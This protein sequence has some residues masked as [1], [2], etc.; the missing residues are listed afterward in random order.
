MAFTPST[1]KSKSA[2]VSNAN[3]QKQTLRGFGDQALDEAQEPDVQTQLDHAMQF[4]HGV[5]QPIQQQAEPSLE[6]DEETL[7][8]QA[9]PGLEEEEEELPV[10]AKLTIGHPGDKYEQEADQMAAK[11]MAMPD[12][13]VQREAMPEEEKENLQMK[14][15]LQRQA[16]SEED[17]ETLQAKPQVQAKGGTPAAPE[18]FEGQ[19]ASHRGGGQPLSDQTRAFMEPRFGADFSD[20][21]VHETADLANVIQAQAFTHGQDVYF[22]SGKYN[23]GSSGGKELLAHELTHVVQQQAIR[24]S[25][26]QRQAKHQS[27][28]YVV[29]DCESWHVRKEPN[30][31]S[32]NKPIQTL[33]RGQRK[34]LTPDWGTHEHRAKWFKVL[35]L[36]KE[37]YI[38][39]KPWIKVVNAEDSKGP[40]EDRVCKRKNG[41]YGHPLQLLYE[42]PEQKSEQGIS[43]FGATPEELS[44]ISDTL[45]LLPSSNYSS[46][47]RIVVTEALNGGKKTGG[48]TITKSDAERLMRKKG[49]FRQLSEETGWKQLPRIELTRDSFRKAQKRANN[50]DKLDLKVGR[51][52]V[53]GKIWDTLLHE[54]GHAVEKVYDIKKHIRIDNF[55]NTCYGG[56]NKSSRCG[57]E[58][59]RFADAYM[60]Y[61]T[62]KHSLKSPEKETIEEVLKDVEEQYGSSR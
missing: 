10:Q 47:P 41:W 16:V 37:A 59:E 18:N 26:V 61:F 6:E 8:R 52:P 24:A 3:V 51:T 9:E 53:P 1:A 43:V 39:K 42:T 50:R 46:I 32:S 20:V 4:G 35:H 56:T 12:S 14:P 57:K 29:I 11:V 15:T 25:Y 44:S 5:S 55:P 58:R 31:Y 34:K 13:A 27:S 28:P 21:R 60:K 62:K 38:Y 19:L 22:N 49:T 23:P 54:T 30:R 2:P 45:S 17:E 40:C 33:K 7:Q 48:G 36:G